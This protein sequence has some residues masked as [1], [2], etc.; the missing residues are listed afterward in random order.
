MPYYIVIACHL[1]SAKP[2]T[3]PMIYVNWTQFDLIGPMETNFNK[4][5]SKYQTF[6]SRKY[7][8]KCFLN[9][10]VKKHRVKIQN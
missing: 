4:T 10:Y 2:L 8:E 3:D 5:T 6:Y 7:T 9:Q 1:Y